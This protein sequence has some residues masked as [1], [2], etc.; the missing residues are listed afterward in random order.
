[1]V[2]WGSGAKTEWSSRTFPPE[3][4]RNMEVS[5]ADEGWER[6]MGWIYPNSYLFEQ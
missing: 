2:V 3:A 1:M 6:R 5:G 4:E